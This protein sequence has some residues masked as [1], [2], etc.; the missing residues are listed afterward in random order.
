MEE[1]EV[2]GQKPSTYIKGSQLNEVNFTIPLIA[3][4]SI[5]IENEID[6]WIKIKEAATPYMLLL[7]NKPVSQNKFLLVSVSVQETVFNVTGDYQRANIQLQFKEFARYGKKEEEDSSDKK[8]D[9]ANADKA[10]ASGSSQKINY[11]GYLM[12]YNPNKKD[13][14]VSKI[15]EKLGGLTVDGYFGNNTLAAV[16]KFQGN[17]GLKVDGIVGPATWAKLFG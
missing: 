2:E 3:Q 4:A 17:N 6:R 5:N 9:N 16:K 10:K 7:A 8:R 14:N 1:Q 11:P 15:Q 13:G 12:M